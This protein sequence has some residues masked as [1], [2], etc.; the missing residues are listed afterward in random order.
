MENR[1]RLPFIVQQWEGSVNEGPIQHPR[2][3]LDNSPERTANN[4][5]NAEAAAELNRRRESNRLHQARYKRKQKQRVADLEGDIQQLQQE[6][7]AL[8][9]QQTLSLAAPSTSNMWSVVAEYFRF[10]S[11]GV[12]TSDPTMATL[13]PFEPHVQRSFLQAAIAE[14]VTD[15]TGPCVASMQSWTTG[16][17]CRTANLG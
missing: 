3:Q 8:K 15:G 14:D 5:A 13:C 1:T 17:E 7:Q 2:L 11:Y 9:M 6:I 10:F 16:Y 4:A 12:R